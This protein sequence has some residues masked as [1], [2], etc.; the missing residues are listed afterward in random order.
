MNVFDLFATLSLN[1]NGYDEG[2]TDAETKAGKFGGVVGNVFGGAAK[3]IT[4]GMAASATAIAGLVK[5]SVDAYADYEQLVGGV[6]TLFG[7]QGQSITDYAKSV[8][9]SVDEI[10]DEYNALENAQST[11]LQNASE[12]YRTAGLSANEYME[13]VTSF[14]AA[15]NSS[16]G[17]NTEESAKKADMAITDMA[18]NANKMGSSMEAIQNAYNGFAKQNYTMLDNLKLGYGG[19]KEEMQRLLD[20][21]EKLSGQKYDLSSYADIVDAIHVVQDE[22]G[23][24]G[25]TAKEAAST[26]SGSWGMLSSSFKNVVMA[27]SSGN[28]DLDKY[29]KDLVDSAKTYLKNLLPVVEEALKGIGYAIEEFLP[30]ILEEIPTLLE[31]FLPSLIE[32]AAEMIT[33]IIQGVNDNLDGIIEIAMTMMSML[34]DTILN[35]LPT[36]V[37]MGAHLLVSLAT[38]IADSLPE[39]IPTIV[40]VVLE[41]V[42]ILTNPDTLGSLITAAIAIML[43]LANGL[44]EAIPQLVEAIPTIIE[45]LCIVIAD[46]LPLIIEAG[47]Q[48]IIMLQVGMIKAF[49]QVVKKI[50]E[51]IV[52]IVQAFGRLYT[53]YLNIGKNIVDGIKTGIK[54]AWNS[55]ISWIEGMVGDL[56][57]HIKGML[58]I[59]SPSRVFAEI[60]DFM[61]QGLGKGWDEAFGDVEKMIS[62]DL[63]F[64]AT[65]IKVLSGLESEDDL[66]NGTV[67][68]QT[69]NV[70][71]EISTAD[72]LAREIRIESRYG[73]MRGVA[74]G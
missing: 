59:H 71:R 7:A 70:N 74:L 73:L 44:V 15:L 39:L 16:L 60:G 8:G 9:K 47:I 33:M 21:A 66:Q 29:F 53:N 68:N 63:N 31:E 50:P 35:N 72:E 43:A 24:T 19:T 64:S 22:M 2:L 36:I 61:V 5:A 26:I 17:G 34:I 12:A 49:P 1:K 40:S 32:T 3:A 67:I 42:N 23:I 58:G 4:A 38:G 54:N 14:A 25:T 28:G 27:I 6:E 37:K 48:I 46:N 45:N 30:V 56:V 69:I 41:I 18:D 13:T 65:P 55:F 11:V 20:D 62:D 52:S 57:D 10:R 51:L